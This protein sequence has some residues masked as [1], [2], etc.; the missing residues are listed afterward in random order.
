MFNYE[1]IDSINGSCKVKI[2]RDRDNNSYIIDIDELITL[3]KNKKTAKTMNIYNDELESLLD[4]I[5]TEEN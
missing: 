1:W 3:Y 4:L 5:I 2:F